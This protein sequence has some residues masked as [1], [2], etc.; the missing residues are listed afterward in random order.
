MLFNNLLDQADK[1][2]LFIYLEATPMGK[3]L[4]L[5]N[6][7]MPLAKWAMLPGAETYTAMKRPPKSQS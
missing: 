1:D 3:P 4:Y 7:F 6:G 2:G 5:K